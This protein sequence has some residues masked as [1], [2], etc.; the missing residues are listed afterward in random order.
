MLSLEGDDPCDG[1]P[2]YL[3][4]SARAESL[5]YMSERTIAFSL[6]RRGKDAAKSA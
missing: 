1:A 4:M 3:L 5:Y 2:C 6:R